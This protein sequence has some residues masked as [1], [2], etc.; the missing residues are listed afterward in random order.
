MTFDGFSAGTLSF[1]REL[2]ANNERE[3][4]TE[5]R[6]RF[7]GELLDRQKA[8]VDAVGVAFAAVDPRVQCV[9]AVNRSIFRINRDTRFARDKSP[10]KTYSDMWFWIGPDRKGAAGYF[11]RIV[12]EGIWV[13][14]GAHWLAPEHLAR[15]RA[16]IIAP[17]T[18]EELAAMLDGLTAEGYELGDKTLARVPAG[19]SAESPRAELLKYTAVHA[20]EKTEPVPPEF[21]GPE[22]VDWCM[23]RF[24]RTKP[25][26]DW[27]A[28]AIA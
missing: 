9:P 14:G 28:D 1:L 15:L 23:E 26:V 22:F 3:W 24:L 19:F 13:G 11:V 17:A 10:Y 2:A 25:L 16:A 5:N 12:P 20:I 27:L 8:F 21:A 7:D 6:A 18:G 4:F